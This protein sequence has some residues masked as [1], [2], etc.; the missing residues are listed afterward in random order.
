MRRRGAPPPPQRN[1]WRIL[2]PIGVVIVIALG[3]CWL[4]YYAAGVADRTLAGWM[5]REAEAGRVY[6]C[7]SQS[8]GGFPFSIDAR[9]T[10]PTAEIND[11]QPK[12]AV[13]AK[14][15]TFGAQVIQPTQLTGQVTG[16]LTVAELGKP[17][18]FVA[19]WSQARLTV[20][21]LPPRPDSVAVVLD[22]PHLERGPDANGTTLFTADHAEMDGKIIEGSADNNPVIDA[23]LQIAA[24]T[25]PT[26]HPLLADPVKIN[27]DAVL[28]GFK[29]LK[30]KPW[31]AR[32]REMQAA[33]GK[34]DIK[35]LRIERPDSIVVGTGTLSVNDHGKLDGLIS[36]GIVGI[37]NIIPRLGVDKLIGQGVDKFTGSQNGQ[38]LSALDR[39]MPGL[40]NVVR[41]SANAGLIDNI[42][43]MGQPTE[44]DKK[45]AIILPLRVS[46]GSVYLAMIRLGSV[47]ALF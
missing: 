26:V 40:G 19:N 10:G 29:D 18:S 25:A 38:G 9:C 43:K 27:I 39:L 32:F 8:V 41:E 42:K 20:R 44:I 16:P 37:E 35:Y 4:W 3:W 14:D 21:G 11:T 36:V 31:S 34:I 12:L 2:A 22:R 45:P 46:D 23:V 5:A 47:P 30:P 17:P 24:A 13:T 33:D 7:G 1:P 15:V 28:R 6:S